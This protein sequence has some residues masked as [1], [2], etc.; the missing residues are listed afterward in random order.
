MQ[1]MAIVSAVL[2]GAS[3]RAMRKLRR[4]NTR[5]DGNGAKDMLPLMLM[6]GD[7][8]D[9]DPMMLMMLM[10]GGDMSAL[11][12]NPMMLYLMMKDGKG[13][14]MDPLMLMLMMNQS[15]TC[16]CGCHDVK[17]DEAATV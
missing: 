1:L 3:T 9:I 7:N 14:D 11:T 13:K 8:K 10:G 6:S 5:Q 2:A 12:A 17:N 16:K 15:H 4:G